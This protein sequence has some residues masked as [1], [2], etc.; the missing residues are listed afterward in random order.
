M[1]LK[2]VR[3]TRVKVWDMQKAFLE[4]VS[5]SA[6]PMPSLLIH[7]GLYC[8]GLPASVATGELLGC[9]DGWN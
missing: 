1:L 3:G 8:N 2:T 6:A 9:L 5:G 4:E 7:K